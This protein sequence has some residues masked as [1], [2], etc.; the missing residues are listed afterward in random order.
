MCYR[1]YLASPLTLSEVRSMLPEGVS[2][3]L[4]PPGSREA[5]LD[6]HPRAR[7]VVELTFGACACDL[8]GRRLA[9]VEEDERRLRDRYRAN[10]VARSL[11]IADLERHRARPRGR[12]V[13]P[14][15]PAEMAGFVAEHGRNAGPS[16]YHLSFTADPERLLDPP[17]GPPRRIRIADVVAEP[18]SWLRD[19][20]PLLVIP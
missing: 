10:R 2:A 17:A 4:A 19:D 16:L 6:L 1:L 13:R 5:L 11:V 14:P 15:S 12:N 7:D 18:A 8:A 3:H 20:A 9:D